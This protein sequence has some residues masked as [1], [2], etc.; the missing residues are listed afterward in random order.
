M[1][2]HLSVALPCVWCVSWWLILFLPDTNRAP[3]TPQS[4][5]CV[6]L[7]LWQRVPACVGHPGH[8]GQLQWELT[9]ISV[10]PHW[11]QLTLLSCSLF[12]MLSTLHPSALFNC[13]L[14]IYIFFPISV[15]TDSEKQNHYVHTHTHTLLLLLLYPDIIKKIHS[16][17]QCF[18]I[19]Q[20]PC[21][22]WLSIS[23]L[24]SHSQLWQTPLKEACPLG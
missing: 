13:L 20:N 7:V 3:A 18:S 21:R 24:L 11:F 17:G 1:Y 14:Y 12:L 2:C 4:G 16:L 19:F 6:C 22:I 8:Q 23:L 15:S 10:Y 9:C 5:V